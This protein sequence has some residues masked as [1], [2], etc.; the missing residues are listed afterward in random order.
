MIQ[1]IV[2]LFGQAQGW[3]F[4]TVIEPVIYLTG[5]GEFTEQAFEGTEWLLIGAC[6]IVLLFIVLR[7]LE[8]LMPAQ[9]ITDPRARWIDFIYTVVHRLGAFAVVVFFVL[10]P[11]MD[12]LAALLHLEGMQPF[13]LDAL[14]PGLTDLPLASFLVYLVVLDFFDYWY[15]R[16]EHQFSWWWGLHSLHHSQQ[17]MNLWSDNRNHLLDDFLRDIYMAIIA[18]GIGVPPAQYVLLVAAS[19]ILQSLQHANVRLHF[20]VVGERLLV[21]P[22]YHRLHHAIGVGHESGGRGTLGGHNFAVLF[23][24]WDILFRTSDFRRTFEPTGIRDQLPP[25]DG[26]GRQYGRGFWAQ[27]WLGLK[28]MAGA[29]RT[30]G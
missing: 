17:N 8:A 11:L 22:R 20:G 7:P 30:V 16:A 24:V 2:D 18:L 6:E 9:P 23:P 13:N 25:P 12:H 27:Q 5:L 15:H 4:Q 19:R 21:S 29:D 10:D 1:T 26:I 14:W 3:L 28:R